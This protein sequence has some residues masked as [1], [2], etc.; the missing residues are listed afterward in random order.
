[1]DQRTRK[2]MTMH[3]VLH[4]ID[5]VDRRYVSRKEGRRGLA[6]IEN[7]VDASIQRLEDYIEMRRWRLITA[8]WN[9]T[10]NMR[11]NRATITRKQKLDEK[12]LYRCFK[13]LTSDISH[14]KTWTWLKKGNLKKETECLLTAVQN[15]AISTNHIKARIDKTQQNSRCRLCGDKEE[16]INQMI[17]ES[18]KLAQKKYKTWHDWVGKLIHW[19]LCKQLK[20]E[21]TDKWCIHKPES[22][23]ETNNLLWDFEIQTDY[24][25][26]A[27]Q[28]N[29]S[30]NNKKK[31]THWIVDSAVPAD[32]RVKLKENEK[33]DKYLDLAREFKKLWNMKVTVSVVIGAL[34]IVTKFSLA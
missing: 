16:M 3:K 26:S 9:N 22:V 33:K 21:H 25:I 19:E 30:I 34:G 27:K 17:S 1:M 32:H 24:L 23:L 28:P 20:L 7:S 29:L 10:D 13:W 5:Y 12:Q 18:S 6:S 2:L 11:T 15:N 31:K 8:T 14:E 4:P